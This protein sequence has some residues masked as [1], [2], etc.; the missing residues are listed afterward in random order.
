MLVLKFGGTS[1]G[2]ADAIKQVADIVKQK[3][4]DSPVLVVVSAMSGTTDLL[5]NCG[6]KASATDES[7]KDLLKQIESRHLDTVKALIPVQQQ[8]SVLSMVKRYCNEIEDICNGIFLLGESS[9]RT[10]DK[11]VS[12]GELLSSTIINAAFNVNGTASLWKDARELIRTNSNYSNAVVDFTVTNLQ[13]SAFIKS[14]SQQLIVVP[15]FIASDASN[16][17]TTLGRGGSD[18][19]ASILAAAVDA[20]ALEIW[21][22]VSGMMTAD[23]RWVPNAKII[24]SISYQEAMELSHFGAKVIYP[25]TI[26]P[27]LNKNIPVWIKNTFAAADHGTVIEHKPEP[28]NIITGISSINSL[29]LLSLEGSG[30]IGIPGFSSRLFA[31]LANAQIN[32]ILI[33]QGSSEHSICV[34]VDVSLAGKAKEIVDR[35]FEYEIATSKVEPLQLEKDLSIVALVGDQMRH[36]TGISGRMF[37]ALGR[38]GINIRAIAQG[39]TERNISAVVATEDVRKAVNVLHEEFFETTKKQVNLYIVGT[40]NVGKKLLAQLKQQQSFLE[41][42]LRLQV[43]IAGLSNSR[44]MLINENG[45]DLNK[46]EELLQNAEAANLEQFVHA[47]LHKN[48]RN[49]VFVDITANAVIADVYASVLEKSIAVVACNKVAASSKL[50]NYKKLKHLSAEYNAPFLFETNVGAGLPIIGT[51]N[52]LMRSGDTIHRM[53]AVLSGTLNFVFNNYDGTKPFADVV[54]QAQDEGYTEPDP[55]LDL[56]G[57]DVMRKI[58]ILAREAGVQMEM[59]Q[60]TCNGFLPESCMKGSVADFYEAMKKEEAHF[61]AIFEKAK[62][63]NC[64]LKFVASYN[65]GIASVGLQH[66]PPQHDLY[67]LYGKDNVVLFYTDRYKEQPM[68]VKGAGAGA[69]V[70]ASGVFADI[71]RTAP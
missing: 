23:P 46:W 35:T 36:H 56:S 49:S 63:E 21:T 29:A 2:S 16:V 57:T 32:V 26:Q 51:L 3:L 61:K 10:K 8:S 64:K 19:T 70:T 44:K 31:A 24:P 30:M 5:L 33:T 22:D 47:I 45:I 71:M 11:L 53:E 69:E 50:S 6:T 14:C 15:G 7:Y 4:K 62:A 1:M 12:Y 37:S 58:L 27:V 43:N 52:D 66:I 39:S 34:G 59:E 28:E 48:L 25:P 42:H 65:N 9:S 13:V 54:K 17:T 40:G 67:H 41:E 18:Y 55:R 20:T 60:I 68:V 38:N